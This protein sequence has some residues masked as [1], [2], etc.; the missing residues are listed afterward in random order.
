[1]IEAPKGYEPT[2]EPWFRGGT[3]ADRNALMKLYYQYWLANDVFDGSELRK[4]WSADPESVFFNTNG[5][6]YYGIDDWLKIWDHYRARM[7]LAKPGGTGAIKITISGDM[8]LITDDHVG[9][10]WNWIEEKNRPAFLIQ[11]PYCR[12]TMVNMREKGEWKTIHVH[13]S[14]GRDGPRPDQG[15]PE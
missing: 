13:F 11:R 14:M 12:V 9:R 5:H 2:K 1:M 15:G 4:I 6:A 10:F 8:A 3:E 7:R